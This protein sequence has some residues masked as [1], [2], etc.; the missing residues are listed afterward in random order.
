MRIGG[1]P[2]TRRGVEHR[3]LVELGDLRSTPGS[4]PEGLP[5]AYPVAATVT[6]LPLTGGRAGLGDA[7]PS[8]HPAPGR[9]QLSNDA[10]TRVIPGEE[11]LPRP[12]PRAQPRP[13]AELPPLEERP[14]RRAVGAHHAAAPR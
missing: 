13:R 5:A 9:P 1:P 12:Q 10:R 2:S 4:D 3:R 7:Q 8:P 11:H 14:A 6:L